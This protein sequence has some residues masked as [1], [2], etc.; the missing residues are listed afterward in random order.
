MRAITLRLCITGGSG[1][2]RSKGLCVA[3]SSYKSFFESINR[4]GDYYQMIQPESVPTTSKE[5]VLSKCYRRFPRIYPNLKQYATLRHGIQKISLGM[6]FLSFMQFFRV[7]AGGFQRYQKARGLTYH[8]FERLPNLN[9]I[10]ISLPLRPR[11]GWKNAMHPG[12]L[13]LFH[14]DAPCPRSLHRLI[15][16]RIADALASYNVSVRNLIDEEEMQR[17]ASARLE[18]I[19]AQKFTEIELEDLYADDEGGIE[20]PHDTERGSG[21]PGTKWEK[22]E[23]EHTE[24]LDEEYFPVFCHCEEPCA[25]S[26]T[27]W[28]PGNH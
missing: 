9:E 20:L 18:A 13:R 23:A 4:L 24:D 5:E 17:L 6:D 12:G 26:P 28:A 8:I 27:L 25:S 14:E 15:Y 3:S 16:E 1:L 22:L 2:T 11:G 7:K 21:M 19:K 10:V